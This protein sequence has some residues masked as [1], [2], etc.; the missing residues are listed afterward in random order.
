[1]LAYF[2]THWPLESIPS[3][4]YEDALRAFMRSLAAHPPQGFQRSWALAVQQLPWANRGQA[5]YEDWYLVEDFA[6][7]G[8][9]NGAAISPP[10]G[11]THLAVARMAGGG[12]GGVY[13]LAQ[14]SPAFPA[15]HGYATWFSKPADLTYAACLQQLAG[16][17]GQPG[18]ALWQRQMVLG[19]GLEFCLHSAEPLALPDGFQALQVAARRV[20][21]LDAPNPAGGCRAPSGGNRA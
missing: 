6:A 5:A 10:H 4:E 18:V 8:V 15:Q 20:G 21:E 16:I 19:P 17:T 7:L 2:F 13:A 3:A 14:G 9:L 1:M 11:E 12:K